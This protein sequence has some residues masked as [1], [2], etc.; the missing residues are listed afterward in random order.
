MVEQAQSEP[1][2]EDSS[3]PLILTISYCPCLGMYHYI[4]SDGEEWHFTWEQLEK[5][6]EHY[7]EQHDEV[8]S[9]YMAKLTAWARLFPHKL[10]SFKSDDTFEVK[11]PP[12][13]PTFADDEEGEPEADQA[14]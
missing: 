4:R 6:I 1:G 3:E 12:L 11:E 8:K 10:V 2:V 7:Q 14:G 13:P 5:S 9:R